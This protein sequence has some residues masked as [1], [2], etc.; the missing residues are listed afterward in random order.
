MNYKR[1][2]ADFIRDRWEKQGKLRGYSER[3]HIVPRAMGGSDEVGNLVRLTPEDHFFAHL[4][5]AKAYGGRNWASLHAMCYLVTKATGKYRPRLRV[6][7]LF[8]H[9]RRSIAA[10]FRSINSGPKG[11]AADKRKHVLRHFNG[12]KAVGNRFELSEKTGVTRQMISGL[13]LGTKKSVHGWYSPKHNPYGLTKAELT[14]LRVRSTV[15]VKLFHHDGR[16]WQ[17][18]KW[19][20]NKEFGRSLFFQHPKGSCFGWYRTYKQARNHG[21]LKAAVLS[22]A[23]KSRGDISGVLNP[24]ADSKKYR[25][26][27]IMTGKTLTATKVEVRQ[28][29]GISSA[30]LSALFSGRQLQ[31]KGVARPSSWQKA[32]A[33]QKRLAASRAQYSVDTGILSRARGR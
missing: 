3:H 26:I 14:S 11:A 16:T 20:F 1:I 19:D 17:G 2:Y 23:L 22:K 33:R 18:T 13:L 24:N 9:V 5:L 28:R 30:D 32:T 6:R 15:V 8:G 29:Y 12:R 21:A 7:I 31:S 27:E 10:Y 25:W 4:L